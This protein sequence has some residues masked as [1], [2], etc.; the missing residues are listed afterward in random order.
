MLEKWPCRVDKNRGK[1]PLFAVDDDRS[2]P[3]PSGVNSGYSA[4]DH[5]STMFAG[6]REH[7]HAQLLSAEP[8]CPTNMQ[9]GDDL[10]G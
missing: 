9:R 2:H 8:T 4:S 5:S 7:I 10:I 1:D 3:A 6:L